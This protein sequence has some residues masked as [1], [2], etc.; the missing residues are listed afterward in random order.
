[1]PALRLSSLAVL[2]TVLLSGPGAAACDES[3]FSL[4]RCQPDFPPMI[5]PSFDPERGPVWTNNGWSHPQVPILVPPMPLY[6]PAPYGPEAWR[7]HDRDRP[8]K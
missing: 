8:L 6:P 4:S 7:S 1:M 2:I 5:V 3:W